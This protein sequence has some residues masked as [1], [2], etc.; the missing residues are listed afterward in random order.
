V[1]SSTNFTDE[2]MYI[3]LHAK[4]TVSV[5]LPPP[6][7][8]CRLICFHPWKGPVELKKHKKQSKIHMTNEKD[9]TQENQAK[10]MQCP[11]I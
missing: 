8:V 9:R 7:Q 10:T 1:H 5:N 4:A 3:R 11:P 6:L 2:H